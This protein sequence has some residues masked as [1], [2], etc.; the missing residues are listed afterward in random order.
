M[1]KQQP[2]LMN[3]WIS[4]EA[5]NAP[6]ETPRAGKFMLFVSPRNIDRYWQL[7][8]D[9]TEAGKLGIAAKT[10]APQCRKL[11][12]ARF[13]G[14]LLLAVYTADAE[15]HADKMRVREGLRELGFTGNLPYKTDA[16]TAADIYNRPPDRLPPRPQGHSGERGLTEQEKID[17]CLRE[18]QKVI[19]A[20]TA[21]AHRAKDE[22]CIE[23]L[24][25]IGGDIDRLL[26]SRKSGI[27]MPKDAM[28]N[29][30]FGRV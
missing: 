19:N 7:I 22:K 13:K 16:D 6:V 21:L 20:A 14:T 30:L 9:A 24:N 12:A 27:E 15:D 2:P 17:L 29:W 10:V 1:A 4:V 8:A 28:P 11:A 5:P 25:N 3:P 26:V 18:A 23:A